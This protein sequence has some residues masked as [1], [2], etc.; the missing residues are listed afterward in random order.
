[1]K[2]LKKFVIVES[3]RICSQEELRRIVG[4]SSCYEFTGCNKYDNCGLLAHESCKSSPTT[5]YGYEDNDGNITCN[6][7]YSF[8]SCEGKMYTSCGPGTSYIS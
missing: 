5:H 7:G 4:G 6:L 3:G 8:S 2:K 1:M